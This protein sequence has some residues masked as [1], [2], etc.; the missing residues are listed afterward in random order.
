MVLKFI[1]VDCM[2]HCRIFGYWALL[3]SFFTYFTDFPNYDIQSNSVSFQDSSST[4]L[5]EYLYKLPFGTGKLLTERKLKE[6]I[7]MFLSS[8][9]LD[10]V[11][12][13]IKI[14]PLLS[15]L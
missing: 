2:F 6:G 9:C 13:S 10:V 3:M 5:C 14:I 11:L 12:S 7:S 4:F 8:P 1:N 15:F